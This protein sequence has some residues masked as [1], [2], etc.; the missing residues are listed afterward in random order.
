MSPS[1]PHDHYSL[2]SSISDGQSLPCVQYLVSIA[3]IEVRV[4][5]WHY[6]FWSQIGLGSEGSHSRHH[7]RTRLSTVFKNQMAK[8]HLLRWKE[9]L[10]QPFCFNFS[11]FCYRWV[12]YCVTLCILREHTS[13]QSE[14]DLMSVTRY[15]EG[16]RRFRISLSWNRNPAYACVSFLRKQ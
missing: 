9:G 14:W 16:S 4:V 13:R 12:V 6:L 15:I 8:W 7:W 2:F 5:Q 11:W 10:T 3:L 1:P